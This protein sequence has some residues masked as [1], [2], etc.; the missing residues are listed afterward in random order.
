MAKLVPVLGE[1]EQKARI[2]YSDQLVEEIAER[3]STGET[4]AKICRDAHMPSLNTVWKWQQGTGERAAALRETLTAAR[5]KGLDAIA[6]E[7]L[8]IAD[9]ERPLVGT[10]ET[11][12]EPATRDKLR[13]ETRLKLL[14]K[15][16]PSRYGEAT[17]IRLADADGGKLDAKPQITELLAIL[18]PPI[19]GSE[20]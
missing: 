10:R 16:D 8:A 3:L 17:Q 7:A 19:P 12:G 9:G 6:E 20:E 5:A 11:I 1:A 18:K 15:W 2:C 13:V 14:A 4:L